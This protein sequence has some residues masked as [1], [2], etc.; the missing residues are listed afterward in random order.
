MIPQNELNKDLIYSVVGYMSNNNTFTTLDGEV[1]TCS[2]YGIIRKSNDYTKLCCVNMRW[3][4]RY[5]NNWLVFQL[6]DL[7][8]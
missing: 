8:D 1:L 2:T 6:V 4:G 3:I 7:D 5:T